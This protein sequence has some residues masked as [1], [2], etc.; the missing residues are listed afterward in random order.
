MAEKGILEKGV[1][2]GKKAVETQGEKLSPRESLAKKASDCFFKVKDLV[3]DQEEDNFIY[4]DKKWDRIVLWFRQNWMLSMVLNLYKIG[5]DWITTL[6]QLRYTNGIFELFTVD[7]DGTQNLRKITD[8]KDLDWILN[9]FGKRI[10][11]ASAE[12][13]RR[14]A[15]QRRREN[16]LAETKTQNERV[17]ADQ[18]LDASLENIA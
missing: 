14:K 2:A 17:E 3:K 6:Y 7:Y 13:E 9:N 18:N 5:D 12:K 8:K 15:E 10:K 16:R 11:E 4:V 1:E